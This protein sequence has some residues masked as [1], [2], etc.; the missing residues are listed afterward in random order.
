[1]FAVRDVGTSESIDAVTATL[2]LGRTTWAMLKPVETS[3]YSYIGTR[4]KYIF[5]GIQVMNENWQAT[6]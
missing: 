3:T 2:L 6:S 1:M 4:K 5:V